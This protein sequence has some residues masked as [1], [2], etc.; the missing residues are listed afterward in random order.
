MTNYILFSLSFIGGMIIMGLILIPVY[1]NIY[2]DPN[3]EYNRIYA[4]GL[5]EG[6]NMARKYFL[7]DYDE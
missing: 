4:E 2:T 6:F 5:E 7:D 1:K 3:I